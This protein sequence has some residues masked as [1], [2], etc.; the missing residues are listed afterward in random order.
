MKGANVNVQREVHFSSFFTF[1]LES[2]CQ[3]EIFLLFQKNG[4]TPLFIA[5]CVGYQEIVQILL[6][7]GANINASTQ[8]LSLF[9][10]FVFFRIKPLFFFPR[11]EKHLF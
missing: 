8:V 1:F 9:F 5:A 7:K 3:T 10:V 11:M 2:N 6:E 4:A